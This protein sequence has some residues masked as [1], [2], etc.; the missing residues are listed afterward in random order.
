MITVKIPSLP[1]C[2]YGNFCPMCSLETK[3]AV[4]SLQVPGESRQ[5]DLLKYL[6]ESCGNCNW[7][8][9]GSF[10]LHFRSGMITTCIRAVT[11]RKQVMLLG[12]I[13]D[14]NCVDAA[15][16]ETKNDS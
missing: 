2:K 6:G 9:I 8:A 4:Y 11:K 1:K 14:G 16:F 10:D 12:L 3:L 7:P 13:H 15:C 5:Q